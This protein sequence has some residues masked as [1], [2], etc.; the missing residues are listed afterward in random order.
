MPY[1]HQ[2]RL[3]S[4]NSEYFTGS[5]QQAR[6]LDWLV[7][8]DAV[9]Y[10]ELL[11]L[12][13]ANIAYRLPGVG[14]IRHNDQLLVNSEFPGV[15]VEVKPDKSAPWQTYSSDVTVTDTALIRARSADGQRTGRAIPVETR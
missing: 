13:T 15:T 2:G 8:R 12:D 5:H 1:H 14:A 9:G 11:K 10:K 7:F 4:Q 3:Y 6:E